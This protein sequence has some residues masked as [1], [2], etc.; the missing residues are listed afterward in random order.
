MG[1]C[2]LRVFLLSFLAAGCAEQ[3]EVA[4]EVLGETQEEVQV[5]WFSTHQPVAVARACGPASDSMPIP[6][7]FDS[8]ETNLS[9]LV[10]AQYENEWGRLQRVC[11]GTWEFPIPSRVRDAATLDSARLFIDELTSGQGN[12]EVTLYAGDGQSSLDDFTA[13]P[14]PVLLGTTFPSG[15]HELSGKSIEAAFAQLRASSH[16][17]VRIV[18]VYNNGATRAWA[19][20]QGIPALNPP[21][22]RRAH[23]ELGYHWFVNTAPSLSLS[24]PKQPLTVAYDA[25]LQLRAF[26]SDAEDGDLSA[27]VTWTSDIA[28]PVG[29]GGS[30][31]VTLM[32]GAHRLTATVSD[33]QGLT[34]SQ[35]SALVT[36]TPAPDP[37]AGAAGDLDRDG[38]CDALDRCH[39][40]DDTRD[41]DADGTP[42]A[43]DGLL[44]VGFAHTCANVAAGPLTCWGWNFYGQATPPA[45]ETFE[46]VTAG[47]VHTCGLRADRTAKCWGD[48]R[49]GELAV[50]PGATFKEL[51]AGWSHTC[52]ITP[53]GS[54]ACWGLNDRGQATPPSG[55]DFVSVKPG[56]FHTCAL[57]TNG[58]ISCWGYDPG[59]GRLTP[60]TGEFVRI[61]NHEVH[62]CALD[63]LG[64]PKCWGVNG[65]AMSKPPVGVA[66]T[67]LSAAQNDT[68][69]VDLQGNLRCFGSGFYGTNTPPS[70]A[71]HT[72]V[73]FFARHACARAASG[74]IECWGDQTGPGGSNS[75]P[76]ALR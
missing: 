24:S 40:Y 46:Q 30:L 26:A 41:A 21:A 29:Q 51:S 48:G 2:G 23:L 7:G 42:D 39:G 36:V 60:P 28:G 74:G 47:Q 67:L 18:P 27:N 69:G 72:Q 35:V 76:L 64:T 20:F 66:F 11:E 50:P 45:G 25:Q 9:D 19:R 17:G 33:A 58:T 56:R 14:S 43:C 4:L 61:T 5:D 63:A 65:T 49:L 15:L 31:Y 37:C 53:D 16:L 22:G 10:V 57:R 52:G 73:A 6:S 38:V 44:T 71:G 8:F 75:V 1:R 13:P 34:A 54:I 62:G 55:N 32:P 3:S 59:F 12:F 70:G 68:C